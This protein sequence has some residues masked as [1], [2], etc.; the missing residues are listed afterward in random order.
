[1]ISFYIPVIILLI[2]YSRIYQVAQKQGKKLEDEK[3][4]LI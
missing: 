4:R 2:L 1:M 3:R